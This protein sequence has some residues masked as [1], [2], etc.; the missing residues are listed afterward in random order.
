MF[1]GLRNELLQRHAHQG[2]R[3]IQT[4]TVHPSWHDTGILAGVGTKTRLLEYGIIPDPAVNVSK[5]ILEQV[6]AGRSG[7]IFVPKDQERMS[8]VRNMS[9]WTYDIVVKNVQLPWSRNVVRHGG[10]KSGET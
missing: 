3:T 7:K 1:P 2:G 5:A 10:E 4:T 8:K 9:L 6:L